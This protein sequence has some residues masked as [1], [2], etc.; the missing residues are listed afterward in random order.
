[1]PYLDEG[2][3]YVAQFSD[4]GSG[5]WLRLSKDNPALASATVAITRID[6]GDIGA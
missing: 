4:D 2:T 1:M 5:E 3:L 6:G